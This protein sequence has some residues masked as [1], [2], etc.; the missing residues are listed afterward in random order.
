VTFDGTPVTALAPL[1]DTKLAVVTPAHAL[2]IVT[3]VLT[4]P[5]GSDTT[6]FTYIL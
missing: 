4:N 1:G 3:V 2:G 6:I 5:V